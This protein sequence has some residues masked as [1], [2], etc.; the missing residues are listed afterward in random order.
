VFDRSIE[1]TAL[2]L[3]TAVNDG[4]HH[5][6]KKGQ[7]NIHQSKMDAAATTVEGELRQAG[8]ENRRLRRRLEELTSSYGAL[9]HQLVQAQ[10]L[11]TK[12]QQQV[13]N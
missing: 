10:Q 5:E 8:E 2:D 6:E 7:S 3:L 13:C 12:H 1:Q 11:H 4:D 9:Y